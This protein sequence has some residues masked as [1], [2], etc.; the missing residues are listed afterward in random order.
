METRR[1]AAALL[2]AALLL[3]TGPASARG[4]PSER[5]ARA[6]AAFETG[7]QQFSSGQFDLARESF[8]EALRLDPDDRVARV[9]LERIRVEHPLWELSVPP[10]RISL[11]ESPQA[12]ARE[13]E[14][15]PFAAAERAF[16]FEKTLGDAR[17]DLGRLESMLGRIAQL[18]AERRVARSHGRRFARL[19]ELLELSR[20]L[21]GASC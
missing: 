21:P 9:S 18:E 7:V 10:R 6:D 12:L 11:R 13:A 14:E 17:S 20:R 3:G 8:Q 2:T 15:S 4:V 5:R 19:A 1:T 16:F